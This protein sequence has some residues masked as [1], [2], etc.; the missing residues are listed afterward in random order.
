[1]G[2]IKIWNFAFEIIILFVVNYYFAG[3]ARRNSIQLACTS[4]SPP[5]IIPPVRSAETS[6]SSVQSMDVVFTIDQG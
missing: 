2:Y 5:L 4:G 6:S 3:P 1:L